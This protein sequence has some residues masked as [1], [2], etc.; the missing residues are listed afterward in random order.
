MAVGGSWAIAKREEDSAAMDEG[1]V[2]DAT[3]SIK[4]DPDPDPDP[5]TRATDGRVGGYDG[6]RRFGVAVTGRETKSSP[7]PSPPSP[8]TFVAFKRPLRD[9]ILK[10]VGWEGLKF[11]HRVSQL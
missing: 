3:V 7:P 11:N 4:T 5:D 10:G 2:T 8:L 1:E 9:E 6:G